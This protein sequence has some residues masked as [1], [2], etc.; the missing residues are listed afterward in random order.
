MKMLYSHNNPVLYSEEDPLT[1]EWREIVADWQGEKAFIAH[2]D[3][4][5]NVQV[6]A[7]A[8]KPGM[9]PMQLLLVA[10]AGCTGVDVSSV[11]QK[12]RQPLEDLQIRVRAKMA[13][14]YPKVFTEIH[15]EYLLW[16][17][18]LDPLAIQRAIQLSEEKYCSVGAHI[19][20]LAPIYS[21]FRILSPGEKVDDEIKEKVK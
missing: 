3:M 1:E 19:R 17:E 20:A 15:M 16:G 12:K 7:M 4:N 21:T 10:L 13:E 8:G 11:L 18:G 6:G 2:N 14:C 5:G 9:S